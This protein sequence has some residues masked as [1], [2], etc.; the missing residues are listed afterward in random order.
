MVILNYINIDTF[1]LKNK[2]Q[3]CQNIQ[4]V[5][6]ELSWKEIKWISPIFNPF[7]SLIRFSGYW[8]ILQEKIFFLY[9]N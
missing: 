3:Y 8:E 6:G 9:H 4:E 1:Y 2:N 5:F 7:F